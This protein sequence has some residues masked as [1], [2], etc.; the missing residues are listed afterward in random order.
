M[1]KLLGM[2]IVFA[3]IIVSCGSNR[4]SETENAAEVSVFTSILPQ[5][6]F[7][8]QIGGDRVDV[9]VLV[10]PGKSPA[11]YEPQPDQVVELSEADVLFTIGVP[12]EN[13]FLPKIKS[14][15]KNI[16][17]V[18]TS[19]GI[20]KRHLEEHS[21]EEEGEKYAH[22]EEEKGAV[23]PHVWMSPLA[24]IRISDNIMQTLIEIDEEGEEQYRKAFVDLE[25]NL[26]AVHQELAE[27][28]EPYRGS[29]F[30]VFHPSFGY[31]ADEYGLE[32]VAVETGGKSPAPSDLEEI[33]EHARKEDVKMIFVQPE[34]PQ[35]SA[36]RIAEAIDGTVVN[37]N[38]LNP[39]Y[40]ENLRKIARELEK[41]LQQ[42]GR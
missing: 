42:H 39:D 40:L 3:M 18:D 16:L 19:E 34:F 4:N 1:K 29:V 24:A 13:A 21:H 33:I 2:F 41:G 5:K 12:F 6:Y 22:S 7:V 27:I 38:P 26:Q 32:Q 11:T 35:K 23:D 14:S 8:E 25:E 9:S 17:I 37:L 31:F 20:E 28:L 15:V 36:E 30:F 10:P